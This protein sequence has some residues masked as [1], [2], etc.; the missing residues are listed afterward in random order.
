MR[1]G[2]DTRLLQGERRGQGHYVY[3]LIKSLLEI[4]KNNEYVLFYNGL[5][6]GEFA[7]DLTIP[8]LQQMWCHMP[9][10]ILKKLWSYLSWPYIELLSGPIDIFHHTMNYNMTHYSPIPTHKKMV[11]TFH[12]MA[13]PELLSASYTYEDCKEWAKAVASSASIIIAVSRMA[14][15]NFL[16]YASFPEDRMRVIYLAADPIFMPI[17]DKEFLRTGLS[18]YGLDNKEYIL[19]VGGGEKNKNLKRLLKAFSTIKAND[20]LYLVLAGGIGVAALQDELKPVEERVIFL[21]HIPHAGLVFLYNGATAFILPTLYEWFGLPVIEAMACGTP[22]VASKNIGALEVVGDA[23]IT[24]DPESSEE[25]AVS[26]KTALQDGRLRI[27]LKEKGLEKV[28]NLSWEKTARETL[29]AYRD[30]YETL[31]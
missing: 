10:G 16:E 6:G 4:D 9:G 11:A 21:N 13:S 23:A 8:N 14:K 31:D 15:E 29:M 30:V 2:I 7:F 22:V 24:F 1:I 5:R 17:E 26:I 28:K 19:Y 20:E 3:Y 18:R 27:K 25:M 12:G